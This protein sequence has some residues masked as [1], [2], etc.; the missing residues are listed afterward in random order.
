MTADTGTKRRLLIVDDAPEN[1]DILSELLSEEYRVQV[2]LSGEKALE[3]AN[4]QPAPDLILLDIMMPVMNG[5]EVCRRLKANAGT[6]KIPVIFVTGMG[7]VDDERKGLE[8]GAV[9]YIAKPF[10][11]PIILARIHTH[12]ALKEARDNLEELVAERTRELALTKDVTILCMASLAETRDNETGNHIRRTQNFLL[13]LASHLQGHPRFCDYLNAEKIELIYKSAPLH[14]IGKVGVPDGILLKPDK[15]TSEEFE[16]MK[17]HTS[18]GY[19]ALQKAERMLGSNSFL[20]YAGQIALTHHER[21]DG[22]GYPQGLKGEEIPV[23]GRLMALV[24]VYDAL[25]SKRFYKEAFSHDRA[26]QII[27]QGDGRTL[28]QH[29]DPDMLNAFIE[30]QEKF[31]QIALEFDDPRNERDGQEELAT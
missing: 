22:T 29:F 18:L 1:G 9:D 3:L 23:A 30:M 2:A 14:D 16:I 12:L 31:R 10:S 27:T 7:G 17:R 19:E 8:L 21:W 20:R 11:P 4:S 6:A 24:D 5:Y 28:P 26:V 15:L 13:A 25:I